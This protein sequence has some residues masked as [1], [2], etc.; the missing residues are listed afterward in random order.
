MDSIMMASILSMVGLTV[1]F[2]SV[3]VFADK[4]LRVKDD[5]RVEEISKLL[6]GVNCGAC[7]FLSCHDFAEH[8]VRDGE[9]PSKCRVV[10]EENSK[11]IFDITGGTAGDVVPKYAVIHCAAEQ[12]HKDPPA[13]YKGVRTCR[14]AVLAFGGGMKCEYGCMGFGDCVAACPFGAI[15]M[16][17]G[18]PRVSIEKCTG[19]GKCVAACPRK[20][21]SLQE[22]EHEKIFYVACNS[23]DL[24][25]R[26]RQVCGVGCIACG[27]CAKLSTEGYFTVV[28]NL[29]V[30]DYSKQGKI[31]EVVKLQVKC[32]TKVI[33]DI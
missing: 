17:K 18:L 11:K 29:S 1:F 31:D 7:G 5:P 33:K 14:G 8:I 9:S 10:P 3:L 20:V 15:T 27:I 21:I 28:D 23:H 24:G 2:A 25:P 6:P 19:C 4:K 26:V 32:P 30:P 12:D 13:E 22:K 16:D